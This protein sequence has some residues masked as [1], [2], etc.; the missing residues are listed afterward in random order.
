MFFR[1][2]ESLAT[3]TLKNVVREL[4]VI[5][6]DEYVKMPSTEQEW[7]KRSKASLKTMNSSVLELGTVFMF[8]YAQN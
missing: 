7:V 4:V 3:Q 1:I 6:F 2:S 5:L 8:V